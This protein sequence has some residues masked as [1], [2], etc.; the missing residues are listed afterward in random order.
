[1]VNLVTLVDPLSYSQVT[2]SS[3]TKN[4]LSSLNPYPLILLAYRNPPAVRYRR[5]HVWAQDQLKPVVHLT[6]R[7]KIPQI[8]HKY[9]TLPSLLFLPKSTKKV[10]LNLPCR[11]TF[12]E[13]FVEKVERTAVVFVPD[14]FLDSDRRRKKTWDSDSNS[15]SFDLPLFWYPFD[16]FLSV[17]L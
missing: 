17:I 16:V 7:R 3:V 1:M 14:C 6:S 12:V 10:S 11:V 9:P 2:S 15:P 13:D 8:Q 5:V 4:R